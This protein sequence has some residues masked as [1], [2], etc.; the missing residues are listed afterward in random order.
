MRYEQICT[1]C[2]CPMSFSKLTRQW[3]CTICNKI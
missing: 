2:R 3:Y 1:K